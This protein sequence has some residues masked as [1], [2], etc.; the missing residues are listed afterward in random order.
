MSN[1]DNLKNKNKKFGG[2]QGIIIPS[3][4]TAQR[5]SEV[6]EWRF[7]SQTGYFEGY[8]G[9]GYIPIA[10]T[11]TVTAVSPTAVDSGA[12]GDETFTIT[13]TNFQSGATVKFIGTDSSEISAG[14]VTVS[15]STS[16]TATATRSSFSNS[17]E[18]YDVKVTNTSG[19]SGQLDNQIDVDTTPT[20]DTASGQIGG[21]IY[22]GGSV[23]TSVSATDADGDTVTYSLQSGSLPSGLSLNTTTGAITG[24]ASAVESDTT[25]TFTIRAT[26]GTQTADR[27]FNIVILNNNA[28]VWSTAAGSLGTVYDSGRSGVSY[29]VVATDADGQSLTYSVL[30]GSLPGGLSLNTSTGAITGTA[31]AVG[32]DTTST[33]T[34]RVTDGVA[35]ADREFSITVKAPVTTVYVPGSYSSEVNTS[36]TAPAGVTAIKLLVVGGGGGGGNNRGNGNGGDG[37][38]GGV[39]YSASYSVTPGSSYTIKAGRGGAHAGCN[40]Q[41]GCSGTNSQFGSITAGMGGG[42][43]SEFANNCNSGYSTGYTVNG[44]S[45]GCTFGAN[46]TNGGNSG[47]YTINSNTYTSV[48]LQGTNNHS[49]YGNGGTNGGDASSGSNYGTQGIVVIGY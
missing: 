27:Q 24:T 23:S 34:I 13:G 41:S 14:T 39:Y 42:G 3:G 11:P 8:D 33:F 20:W 40:N 12:G 17:L 45:G 6:G 7:N 47:T 1:Y 15:S 22:E 19:L 48:G 49:Q 4:T 30:S 32:S 28:P 43:V 2:T 36:W 21:T 35:N 31:S 5:G 26:G 10:V 44:G 18:S 9:T 29:T 25:S 46:G 38:G 16:L 37:G